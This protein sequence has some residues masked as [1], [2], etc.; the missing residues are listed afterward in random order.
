ME[1][2]CDDIER[3]EVKAFYSWELDGKLITPCLKKERGR[4]ML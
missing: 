2:S 4:Q 3:A 1:G